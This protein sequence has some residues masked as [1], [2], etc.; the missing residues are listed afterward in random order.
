LK[1]PAE[2]VA[3]EVK[4][5]VNGAQSKTAARIPEVKRSIKDVQA[6][7]ATVHENKGKVTDQVERFIEAMHTLIETRKNSLLAQVT[8]AAQEK[9]AT[10]AKQQA[11]LNRLLLY[12]QTSTAYVAEVLKEGS[13]V[14]ILLEKDSLL[15]CM[16]SL[17]TTTWERTPLDNGHIEFFLGKKG[18]EKKGLEAQVWKTGGVHDGKTLRRGTPGEIVVKSSSKVDVRQP[19]SADKVPTNKTPTRPGAHGKMTAKEKKALLKKKK[20]EEKRKQKEAKKKGKGK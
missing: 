18:E 20:E 6:A 16:T 15:H 1:K 3:K 8:Q 13:E 9:D 4:R 12:L 5:D 11:D 14:E 19:S 2:E 7:I 17:G 10:L